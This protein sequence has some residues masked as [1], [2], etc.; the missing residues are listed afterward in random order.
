M[1]N[2]VVLGNW[3][4]GSS[5]AQYVTAFRELGHQVV[6]VGAQFTQHDADRWAKDIAGQRWCGW[7]PAYDYVGA[8][9][10]QSPEPDIKT[11]KGDGIDCIEELAE[12]VGGLLSFWSYGETPTPCWLPRYCSTPNALICGDTHT[13]HLGRQAEEAERWSRTFVQ[14]RR[15]DL[16]AFPEPRHWLPAAANPAIWRRPVDA[17]RPIDV[18]FVGSTHPQVHTRRVALLEY[19]LAQ[20]VSVQIEHAFGRKA[21]DLMGQAKI[22]LNCSLADDLNMRVPEALMSGAA[23]VTDWVDGLEEMELR[24]GWE[25]TTYGTD[26]E[27]DAAIRYLLDNPARRESIARAGQAVALARHTYTKRAEFLLETMG[28]TKGE[29]NECR[30]SVG[31]SRGSSGDTVRDGRDDQYPSGTGVEGS[32]GSTSISGARVARRSDTHG[33]CV[34]SL[35][36]IGVCP[37]ADHETPGA[38]PPP[39]SP[40]V[41]LIIPACNR[42]EVTRRLV[43]HLD[44]AL[45]P[46]VDVIVV[47]DGSTDTTATI[48]GRWM[49]AWVLHK[50]NGGF[51]SACNFG[52]SFSHAEHL[53]FLNND[54]MPEDGWLAP[55]L[56]ALDSG[57]GVVGPVLRFP[58][59]RIQSAGME[60]GGGGTWWNKTDHERWDEGPV[61]QQAVT[62]ACLG[63]S[64]SLF[65]QL[66]GFD[67]AFKNGCEDVDLCLRARQ[68][69]RS[70]VL[71]PDSVVVHEEGGTRFAP[72]RR[73]TAQQEVAANVARLK[74]R[75]GDGNDR[76][77]S[78]SG[79]GAAAAAAGSVCRVADVPDLLAV[80]WEGPTDVATGGSLAHI[81][82]ELVTRL[83]AHGIQISSDGAAV[84]VSHYWPG[85][86]PHRPPPESI[87]H[88]AIVQPWEIG[89]P[90]AA[91]EATWKHPAFRRL[92]TPSEHS[93]HLFVQHT[94]LLPEQVTV[95]PNGVDT[96]LFTPEGPLLPRPEGEGPIYRFLFVGGLIWRKGV[97]LL[98]E[99]WRLAFRADEPVRLILKAQG[100]DAFYRGQTLDPPADLVNVKRSDAHL[101][102]E[103]MAML[104]RSCDVVVCPSRAEG[105]GLSALEGMASGRPVI[106]PAGSAMSE[107]VPGDAG[108]VVPVISATAPV[109]HEELHPEALAKAMRYLYEHRY[110]AS[111][112][113]ERGRR[114][115]LAYDWSL[116][117]QQ[118]ATV[119]K[120]IAK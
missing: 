21:A 101:S 44:L 3:H 81:N 8:V 110:S 78:V 14:Y 113:G 13:G 120:E 37:R 7:G 15:A 84:Q 10:R 49:D 64:R 112:L 79:A 103:Q 69:G 56:H 97:D 89:P 12:D 25:V 46:G 66:G 26:A 61:P 33:L 118:Y 73:E 98:Y 47:D 85:L 116:V 20:G 67:E 17:N 43:D 53:V 111:R 63:I 39:P 106:V 30:S 52:A 28:V 74:E 6:T 55:L 24:Q 16:A 4:A 68:M 95:V 88:W 77:V 58:D 36:W 41:S 71:V 90:P 40:R 57:A 99:A 107:C 34:E 22:V 54:T 2:L 32:A 42:W 108:L 59:G 35:G 91:W 94:R 75:W 119:L 87:K 109:P 83:P 9:L 76:G 105:F 19:L 82:H 80:A 1:A 114:A 51:A 11:E 100:G 92:I 65:W 45:P 102:P 70:V 93:R 117:A 5:A 38:G 50:P 23:L 115:A 60:R 18:L 31:V 72:E 29:A 27:C 48:T 96:A 86:E 62:G 104:Y